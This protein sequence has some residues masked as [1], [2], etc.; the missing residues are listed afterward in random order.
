MW[1]REPSH[2]DVEADVHVLL[3]WLRETVGHD[4]ATATAVNG[5]CDITAERDSVAPWLVQRQAMCDVAARDS[6]H[7]HIGEYVTRMAPWATWLP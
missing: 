6:Y 3:V 7:T 2:R 4:W 5:T 1:Q